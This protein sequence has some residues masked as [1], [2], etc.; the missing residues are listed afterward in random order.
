[1]MEDSARES[2]CRADPFSAIGDCSGWGPKDDRAGEL[3][4][5]VEDV[6]ADK[7]RMRLEGF[8]RLGQPYDPDLAAKEARVERGEAGGVG[9][10]P[11]LY[12][13]LEYDR[14]ARAFTRF[15][16]AAL[17]DYYGRLGGSAWNVY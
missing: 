2:S 10:E 13:H 11:E 6:S 14:T 17:G 7:L 12:G 3:S 16:L 5:V 4:V 8:A 15:D 1:M 9:D